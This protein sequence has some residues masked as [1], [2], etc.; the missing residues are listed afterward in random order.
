MTEHPGVTGRRNGGRTGRRKKTSATEISAAQPE[1]SR[2][3][4]VDISTAVIAG[5]DAPP[6]L[7]L[8]KTPP[9]P[10]G[11]PL[12]ELD[13]LDAFSVIQFCAKHG[14]SR[15]SFYNMRRKGIG[16][17]ELHILGRVLI[18]R[19]SAARWRYER[20]QITAAETAA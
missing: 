3:F 6:P 16:P 15:G 12:E 20:E 4:D 10:R 8:T 2:E 17:K 11:P 14:L 18:T 9:K 5:D 13:A 1:S 19:E 7:A